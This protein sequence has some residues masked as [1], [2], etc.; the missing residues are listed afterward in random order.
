[1]RR[2]P[3]ELYVL[4]IGIDEYLP[5]PWCESLHGAV[6]DVTAMENFLLAWEV[7]RGNLVKLVSP[8]PEAAYGLEAS[9]SPLPTYK[10]MVTA[11]RRLGQ[12]AARAK[13]EL[14]IYYSGHGCRTATILPAVKGT[15]GR[16]EGLVPFD[17]GQPGSRV[18]R[19]VELSY[20]FE[21]ISTL[22]VST[23]MILDACHSGGIVRGTHASDKRDTN[24]LRS[25]EA[26]FVDLPTLPKQGLFDLQDLEA[27]WRRVHRRAYATASP[28]RKVQ[29][30]A[31]GSGVPPQPGLTILSACRDRES[32]VEYPFDEGPRGAFTHA[33]LAILGEGDRLPG[34]ERLERCLVHRL[35][36]L[37]GVYQT[38]VFE[39]EP[40]GVLLGLLRQ[41][42]QRV[43]R[44]TA[45]NC[46]SHRVQVDAGQALGLTSGAL[47][48]VA[49]NVTVEIDEV[50][51]STAWGTR[52]QGEVAKVQV[53]DRATVIDPGT[54]RRHRV[55]ILPPAET[56]E[57][58]L[59][60]QDALPRRDL[61]RGGVL[62]GGVLRSGR[63]RLLDDPARLLDVL[64]RGL[65]EPGVRALLKRT[66]DTPKTPVDFT[67]T[68]DPRG[69]LQI[70]QA[71]GLPVPNLPP[72]RP[73]Q[74]GAPTLLRDR[75]VHLARFLTVRDL[76]NG[77]RSSR[78]HGTLRTRLGRLP[79]G[80]Q[81]EAP[82]E[83]V[84]CEEACPRFD[85]AETVC[86]IVANHAAGPL[87]LYVL[88]LRPD[89]GIQLVHPLGSLEVLHPGQEIRLP[90]PAGNLRGTRIFK[91]LATVKPTNVRWLELPPMGGVVVP[92]RSQR[93][94]DL[95]EGF[96]RQV[97]RGQK[98]ER[99][100]GSGA[101][102]FWVTDRVECVQ[103]PNK[104]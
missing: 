19:D 60:G 72:L 25:R 47:L 74:P 75:L 38:P 27:S 12:T 70:L 13:G 54:R 82:L 26:R 80:F 77:D 51:A 68:L 93:G 9:A 71:D 78:L 39:G 10:A 98:P 59:I 37:P 87:N 61:L 45:V 81:P 99:G 1:M 44:V 21:E 43:L 90:F 97:V 50:D 16:D 15:E 32:A 33:L 53:G 35:R 36:R 66:D 20:L 55:R 24:P 58:P 84:H 4:L 67:V 5:N 63:L 29:R 28:N 69:L 92:V 65:E 91:A 7:P 96:F 52:R 8:S 6:A 83:P 76:E 34:W 11:M 89:W 48:K 85:S 41:G 40:S 95:L 30:G 49:G 73:D 56:Q 22:G 103:S 3:R 86:L 88:D 62:R 100:A 104:I 2:N 17:L 64:R 23:T 46:E 14:L 57:N 102:H 101:S 31:N 94:G 18:L 79:R 42:A